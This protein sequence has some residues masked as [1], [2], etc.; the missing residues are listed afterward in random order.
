MHIQL[1]QFFTLYNSNFAIFESHFFDSTTTNND[2]SCFAKHVHLGAQ[3]PVLS[4]NDHP[5]PS[6]GQ[7]KGFKKSLRLENSIAYQQGTSEREGAHSF[8]QLV[9]HEVTVHHPNWAKD[10]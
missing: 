2:H 3:V 7:L 4:P 10:T 6:K 9:R 1:M 5:N 8:N